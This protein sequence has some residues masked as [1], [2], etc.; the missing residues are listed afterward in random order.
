MN[1]AIVER[2][3][4]IK[5]GALLNENEQ[6]IKYMKTKYIC[7]AQTNLKDKDMEEIN[8][9]FDLYNDPPPGRDL[10]L[11]ISKNTYMFN[12]RLFTSINLSCKLN[13]KFNAFSNKL[14]EIN[15]FRLSAKNIR[16]R[17]LFGRYPK[18]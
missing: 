10:K 4:P 5:H 7:I 8:E 13:K 14:K 2:W 9:L 17:E 16:H 18:K 6:L 3:D 11:V 15:R 12:E 1:L